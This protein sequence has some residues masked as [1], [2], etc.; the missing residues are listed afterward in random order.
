MSQNTSNILMIRPAAFRMNEETAS[1]N[2]YQK[3]LNNSPEDIMDKAI[4][5]FD[6]MVDTLRSKGVNVIV[7]EDNPETDTPDCLFPNNWISFHSD[8][9]VGLY[10]MYAPN[11]REERREDIIV[12]LQH[13][14]NFQINEVVDF[15]EFEDHNVYLEGTGS[16]VLDRINK[17]AYATLSPRT[18]KVAFEKFCE[19]M[20][21][22][23]I[24]FESM[25]SVGDSREQIYH[26]NVMMCIG[27]GWATVCLDSIDHPEDKA[28]L[29]NSLEEDGLEV[30][31]LSE[32]Q[33]AHFAGNMLEV[34]STTDENPIIVMSS[35]AFNSLN[36]DQK[37][38]LEKYGKLVHVTLDFIE[39]CGGGSARCM[40]AEI[41]L[42][43]C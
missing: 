18:D 14:Y 1:N 7:F 23:G 41:H 16:I 9:R 29:K 42:P 19:A 5:E 20:N 32:D 34:G 4:E 36:S 22:E 27:T 3:V 11:R 17:K 15:T 31:A 25:Q 43:K 6:Q 24:V 8:S 28:L 10:P 39:A 30:I 35:S 40:M 37:D 13:V 2:Y 33:I 38:I 21:Y 12:D 26:T